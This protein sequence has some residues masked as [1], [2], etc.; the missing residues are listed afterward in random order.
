[1]GKALADRPVALRRCMCSNSQSLKYVTLHGK[2]DFADVI[3][4]LRWRDYPGY[5]SGPNK[6]P[7]KKE[8][9]E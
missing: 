6:S 2:G 3:E 7:Y 9:G 5:L 1:M 8:A 4:I